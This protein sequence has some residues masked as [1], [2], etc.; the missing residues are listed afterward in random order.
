[1]RKIDVV[2]I[3]GNLAGAAC[4]RELARLGIDAVAFESHRFPRDKVCG[5]F[6]SPGGVD[7][8]DAL[9][10]LSAVQQAGGVTVDRARINA[11]GTDVDVAFAKKGIGISRRTLDAVLA[12]SAPVQQGCAVR[13]V[14]ITD[15]GFVVETSQGD[16]RC[17]V[18]IDA[19]GKLSRF[20]RRVASPEFGV[21]YFRPE[22]RGS[23]LDFWFF[24]DGYGGAVSVDGAQSNFC[25]L[26]KKDRLAPYI[27]RPGCRVTGPVSYASCS[28]PYVTIGD[29]AGMLDPF[30]GEGMHHAL[31]SG[32]TAAKI[33]AN[34]LRNK[35]THAEMKCAYELEWRRR[36]GAKRELLRLMRWALHRPWIFRAG[37]R[38]NPVWFLNRLWA[39]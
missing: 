8:L 2:I 22:P 34:G 21:Q 17:F 7:C 20:T 38:W 14:K 10:L 9:G 31:D 24:Q 1:M 32:I 25:F 29:A 6:V 37:I 13:Q 36:W 3:G 15:D 16:T 26:I 39:G 19:A 5:G 11:G 30:C 18:L 33:V 12:S 23:T 27:S 35:K 28:S 4:A